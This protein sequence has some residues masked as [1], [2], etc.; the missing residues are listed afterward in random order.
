[1][2][3][4]LP[5][6]FKILVFQYKP[7]VNHMIAYSGETPVNN[8]KTNCFRKRWKRKNKNFF[9]HDSLHIQAITF[10]DIECYYFDTVRRNKCKL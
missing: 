2:H 8:R 9:E 1:M 3:K 7:L 4:D 10:A 5:K 6:Y